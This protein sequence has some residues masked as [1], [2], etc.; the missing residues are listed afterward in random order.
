[1]DAWSVSLTISG[2]VLGWWIRGL[3]P[4]KVEFP[5][6]HCNCNCSHSAS[7][8]NPSWGQQNWGII[9][10]T[11]GVAV[12]LA[13]TALACKITLTSKGEQREI[14]VSV[15]GKSKGVYGASRPFQITG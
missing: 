10:I 2:F 9:L 8:D 13:N 14:A 15:K 3:V 6:C 5:P 4:E 7:L 12:L 1:M 11:F